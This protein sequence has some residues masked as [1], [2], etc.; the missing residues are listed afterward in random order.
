MRML[1]VNHQMNT[2]SHSFDVIGMPSERTLKCSIYCFTGVPYTAESRVDSFS[3]ANCVAYSYD[4][5]KMT[6]C[7]TVQSIV[8]HGQHAHWSE[9]RNSQIETKFNYVRAVHEWTDIGR[10][11]WA[12]LL[13][14][15]NIT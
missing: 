1:E 15:E 14:A 10:L 12:D 13:S 2:Q 9:S 11:A 4:T 6:N 8:S 3:I 5:N 7:N